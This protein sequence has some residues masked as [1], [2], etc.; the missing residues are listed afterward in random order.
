M[1]KFASDWLN[2]GATHSP[3]NQRTDITDKKEKESP[4]DPSVS[5]VSASPI[6]IQ[7]HASQV[8]TQNQRTDITDKTDRTRKK[9]VISLRCITDKTDRTEKWVT[10]SEWEFK[11]VGNSLIGKRLDAPGETSWPIEPSPEDK[12]AS[13][14]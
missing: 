13:I 11:R 14:Q 6:G 4:D 10:V 5:F 2:W 12:V 1:S 9:G 7:K 3:Q 8:N